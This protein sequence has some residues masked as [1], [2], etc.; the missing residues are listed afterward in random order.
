M[1][2]RLN[3]ESTSDMALRSRHPIAMRVK[4]AAP[5]ACCAAVALCLG[6]F[7][8]A[9]VGGAARAEA[10]YHLGPGDIVRVTVYGHADL[11]GEF[12]VSP[13]G[14]IPIPLVGQV[15]A[16]GR[17][18]EELQTAITDTLKPDYLKNPQ[19]GV[20]VLNY[21]PF[22]II[23]EVKTPGSYPYVS[24][25]RVV[26]AVAMAGGYTY[27]ADKDDIVI[28]RAGDPGG[29]DASAGPDSRVLPGDV[30]EVGERFF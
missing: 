9:V 5:A 24:G 3:G 16:E 15:P 11:S 20:E 1:S 21:R 30:I 26:N 2:D 28:T 10:E 25:M 6:L 29:N 12:E 19:V 23:G 27:R 17:T 4:A 22:Y 7:A 14:G 13:T 18:A 8:L